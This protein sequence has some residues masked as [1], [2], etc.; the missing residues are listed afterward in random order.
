MPAALAGAIIS[1]LL[2]TAP[3][4]RAASQQRPV[5]DGDFA[6]WAAVAP[7][8]TDP[9]GDNLGSID[10]TALRCLSRGSALF[11]QIDLATP[12]N[13]P[14]GPPTDSNLRLVLTNSLGTRSIT[15]DLRTRTP[16]VDGAIVTWR[17]LDFTSAPTT[18]SARIE[19]RVDLAAIG[20]GPGDTV[21]VS[22][23]QADTLGP[24]VN[25]VLSGDALD[26]RRGAMD[27]SPCTDLRVASLNTYVTGS[28]NATR[29]PQL[30]RLVDS[31]NA[32]VYLFQEEYNST[33]AGLTSFLNAADPKDDALP[34]TVVKSGE[35]AIASQWPM[36]PVALN[37]RHFAALVRVPGGPDVFVVCVHPSCCGYA[38][39]GSDSDRIA[40]AQDAIDDVARF[41]AGTLLPELAPFANAPVIVGG[42]W[43]LVGSTT[44]RDLWMVN[45]APGLHKVPLGQ[46]IG[47]DIWTWNTFNAS[48]TLGDFW[49]G[50]LDLFLVETP[51]LF[52]RGGFILDTRRMNA[53]ELATAGL[54]ANDSLGSDHLLLVA[55]FGRLPHADF[56]GNGIVEDADFQVFV[57]AYD[58]LD[59]ADAAM[60]AGCPSDLNA[61]GVVDDADF[62]LFVAGY[63]ELVCP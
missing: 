56:S 19:M 33:A 21:Q 38:G 5:I 61:D 7:L 50:V 54:L 9:A 30:R 37:S 29:A 36:I 60:P 14:D 49:P 17:S 35:L 44:P 2:G 13:L 11:L 46:L 26:V 27:R 20:I 41:R 15:L 18:A 57:V 45:P 55:D 42:D 6:E 23:E 12:I 48:V 24:P 52:T 4:A 62:I 28:T 10:L 47:D 3:G 39:S 58:I 43:N 25:F 1:L 53:A 32:D 34:W 16:R 8:A 59:C 51:R 63:N 40:L 22:F 31:V